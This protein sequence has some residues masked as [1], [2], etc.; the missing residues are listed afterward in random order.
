MELKTVAYRGRDK[1]GEGEGIK[2]NDEGRG[3]GVVTKVLDGWG[4][5]RDLFR[6]PLLK[7]LCESGKQEEIFG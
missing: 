3:G 7:S 1:Q 4:N 5:R 6:G 2:K